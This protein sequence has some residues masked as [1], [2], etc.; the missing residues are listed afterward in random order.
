MFAFVPWALKKLRITCNHTSISQGIVIGTK[1]CEELLQ[2]K[3]FGKVLE[4]ILLFG[5][6]MNSGSNKEQSLGFDLS[7]LTKVRQCVLYTSFKDS[8]HQIG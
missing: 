7:Y 1:A 5:N 4:I 6:Y 2:S 3:K 8:C